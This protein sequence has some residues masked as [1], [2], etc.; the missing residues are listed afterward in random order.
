MK[1]IG[2]TGT[3]QG[4]TCSQKLVVA[5]ILARQKPDKVNHGMC[6]GADKDFDDICRI[7]GIWRRGW[8]G[9]GK[10]GTCSTRATCYDIEEQM[11]ERPYKVRDR[12]IVAH[13][14]DGLIATPKGYKE[15][16]RSGTWL[17]VRIARQLH[18]VRWIVFPDGT[19]SDRER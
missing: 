3:R 19:I 13:G 8:P 9:V 2:F 1:E 11:G 17:T 10:D 4:M 15:E 5:D 6:I 18:V 14:K 16:L 7:L 12:L